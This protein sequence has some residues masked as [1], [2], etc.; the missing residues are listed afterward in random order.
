MLTLAYISENE[1]RAT[2]DMLIGMCQVLET[3]MAMI[4]FWIYYGYLLH[5]GAKFG[6]IEDVG[7][8]AQDNHVAKAMEPTLAPALKPLKSPPNHSSSRAAT[9]TTLLSFSKPQRQDLILQTAKPVIG[10]FC[11][12]TFAGFLNPLHIEPLFSSDATWLAQGPAT[13]PSRVAMYAIGRPNLM[14]KL[15]LLLAPSGEVMV[16]IHRDRQELSEWLESLPVPEC[17]VTGQHGYE[18]LHHWYCA[19]GQ[20]MP[21]MALPAE[22]R[23]EILK[24][25][26]GYD[27]YPIYTKERGILGYG[28]GSLK[29]NRARGMYVHD[30]T[31]KIVEAPIVGVLTLNKKTHQKID[32]WVQKGTRKCFQ[33]QDAFTMYMEC[34]PAAP[35]S[36]QHLQI[37]ELELHH[38]AYIHLFEV[39]VLPFNDHRL[40]TDHGQLYGRARLFAALPHLKELC[41]RFRAPLFGAT[42]DPWGYTGSFFGQGDF[43]CDSRGNHVYDVVLDGYIKYDTK[44]KWDHIFDDEGNGIHHDME[45]AKRNIRTWNRDNL[46]PMC[47]CRTPCAFEQMYLILDWNKA[48]HKNRFDRGHDKSVRVHEKHTKADIQGYQFDFEGPEDPPLET[49]SEEPEAGGELPW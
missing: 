37:L 45:Q 13:G 49:P 12:H 4:A 35:P 48:L 31:P 29:H 18:L 20:V 17:D 14:A 44:V 23:I 2:C 9:T 22:I 28:E 40:E 30:L 41:L 3:M 10:R 11:T 32:D 43:E 47:H 33:V 25:A 7:I 21:I 26:F 27:V 34:L 8:A 42:S 39:D 16:Q 36:F 24:F 6:D 19:T 1:L 46:G 5:L 38:G 15:P